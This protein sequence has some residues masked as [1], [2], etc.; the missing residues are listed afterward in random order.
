MSNA[1]KI[2]QSL[3]AYISVTFAYW[4]FML[5]D[6]AVRMLVLFHFHLL[7]FS[8]IELATIFLLY[9]FMGVITNLYAGY[10]AARL[11]LNSTLYA[12]LGFQIIALSALALYSD[13]LQPSAGLASFSLAYVVISQGLSGIA[14]DLTKMSAK[15]AV[16]WLAPDSD[17]TLFR[18]VAFL[19]GSKNAVKGSGFLL[20]AALLTFIGFTSALWS[21]VALL[22]VVL[23][24]LVFIMPSGLTTKNKS[25]K[26][27]QVFSVNSHINWLSGARL[28]LFGAR[29]VWFVVG[30]PIFFYSILSD[31]SLSQNRT[32]FFQIGFFMSF[33]IILYGATQA[34][35]PKLLNSASRSRYSII[36]ITKMAVLFLA[37]I[38]A[39]LTAVTAANLLSDRAL[40]YVIVIGLFGFGFVFAINSSLHSYLILAFSDAERVT[41]DVGFYYMS[42]AAGR[43]LG[44][45]LSGVSYQF[46][47]LP[48]CL[49]CATILCLFS[50]LLT[51]PLANL[52]KQ[53]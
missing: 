22:L 32:A 17:G 24:L 5:T 23:L 36:R 45:F 41:M 16:K 48:A 20:G 10:I 40:F 33:W 26:L 9:E 30:I 29:D 44:T 12:G 52:Q 35:T 46:G 1:T 51:F 7:G 31:G 11:G 47:G 39:V 15:S 4:S 13:A 18:W 27:K 43:L 49:A 34:I 25:A 14:K 28:F 37:V 21:L 2:S 19:T 6:G 53:G 3:S 38:L 50:W 8:P 42:N